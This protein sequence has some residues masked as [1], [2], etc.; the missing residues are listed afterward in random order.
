SNV[1]NIL[2]I[3][4]NLA[5]PSPNWGWGLAERK[6]LSQRGKPDL[7][8][9]LALIHHMV[10]TANIPVEE[11]VAWLASL[12]GDLVIEFVSRDD[13]M[14]K[15]LLL[16]KKDQ[17]SDYYLEPFEASLGR[18]FTIVERVSLGSGNRYLFH[19]TPR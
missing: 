8:L 7:V 10:I 1:T 16:N 3:V 12:G 17:Y 14:V 5:D 15:R 6:S 18:H 13:E 11:F 9:A 19:C 4:F 2:P